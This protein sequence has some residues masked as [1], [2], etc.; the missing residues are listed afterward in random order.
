MRRIVRDFRT[1][2][3]SAEASLA[4]WASVRAGEEKYIFPYTDTADAILNT[5]YIYE[6]G[7]LKVYVEPLLYSIGIESPYYYDARRLLDSLRTF[8]AIP[9]EYV[10]SDN[11]LREFIGNSSFEE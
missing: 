8:Y 2:G 7:V 3:K 11:L 10:G 1:R 6:I 9:S 4:S 5:A